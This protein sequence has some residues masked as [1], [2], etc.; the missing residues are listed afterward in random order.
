MIENP[1]EEREENCH[2]FAY[3]RKWLNQLTL[4]DLYDLRGPGVIIGSY[5]NNFA[6]LNNK[7]NYIL[8]IFRGID[9]C[10]RSR[11]IY[12]DTYICG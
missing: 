4:N 7:N 9:L 3:L 6:T 12:C 10:S 2:S 1:K 8:Y 5:D 11:Y